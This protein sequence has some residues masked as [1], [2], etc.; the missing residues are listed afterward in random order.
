[1]GE[2]VVDP[3][4]RVAPVVVPGR[5]V[6]LNFTESNRALTSDVVDNI[7]LFCD[8]VDRQ[9]ADQ[10]AGY[11]IGGYNE[12]RTIYSRSRLFDNSDPD[13]E[14]RRLHLGIDIWARAGTKV[15][16]P[17]NGVLHSKANNKAKGDYGAT[18]ILEHKSANSV[19]YSL[20]GHLSLNSLDFHEEGDHIEAG[21][22][23]A[24]FGGIEEN[25]YW[26]PHLHFQ[27]IKDLK[28]SRGDYPGVCRFSE[29]EF[30]LQNSPDPAPL[31]KR[32]GLQF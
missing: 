32:G 13:A 24:E 20:Y 21:T 28:G 1:M 18:I 3:M 8:Y 9:L 15:M 27:L 5:F 11:G 12:H 4:V 30:W 6:Q 26:P 14:P 19:F 31:L 10:Y 25:G 23:I 7:D 2:L 22:A 17:L 29:R 16:T